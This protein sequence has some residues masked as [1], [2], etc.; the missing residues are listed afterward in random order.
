[1]VP[2]GVMKPDWPNTVDGLDGL[3]DAED[4]AEPGEPA[5]HDRIRTEAERGDRRS[6]GHHGAVDNR[7]PEL[8]DVE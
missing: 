3:L 6:H 5:G 2:P 4:R 8:G 1:M 7:R